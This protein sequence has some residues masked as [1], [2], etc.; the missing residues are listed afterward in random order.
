MK[1]CI[2]GD[3]KL[4]IDA[5]DDSMIEFWWKIDTFCNL[6]FSLSY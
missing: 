3:A 5:L 4:C 2:E 1:I 6:L